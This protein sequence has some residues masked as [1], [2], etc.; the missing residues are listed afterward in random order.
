MKNIFNLRSYILFLSRNKLYTTIT[1][2]GFAVSL[3]FVILMAIYAKDEFTKDHFHENGDRIYHLTTG[4]GWDVVAAPI[5]EDLKGRYPEIES[6]T[7]LDSGDKLVETSN[8][9][10]YSVKSLSVDSSFFR[11]F[12]FPFLEGTASE[13][14]NSASG[15]VLS[16]EFAHKLFGSKSPLG[17]EIK[18]STF[19][20]TTSY[21][22]SGVIGKFENTMFKKCDI[23]LPII[24]SAYYSAC[25]N[26]LMVL[27]R[28]G[29]DLKAKEADMSEFLRGFFWIF[30]NDLNTKVEFI[31]LN[32][33]Y[34]NPARINGTEKGDERF[35]LILL[36]AAAMILIF[37]VIN[38]INLSVAQSGFRAREMA[39]RRL[40]GSPVAE[41]FGKFIFESFTMCFIAFVIGLFLA[42]VALPV[43]ND[44]VQASISFS[45]A[46][47]VSNI[48]IALGFVMLL[49]FIS[50]IIPAYVITKFKP[51][52]VVKGTFKY[53][54]KKVYSK[55]LIAFQYCI[56]IVLIGSA[57]T[58]VNQTSFMRDI[59]PGYEIENLFV[60]NHQVFTESQTALRGDL[61][62][63]P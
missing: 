48:L 43:F 38:Y 54:T 2:F 56:T 4:D 10:K 34:F 3:M 11:M 40:L 12:D 14:F 57:M 8:K 16:E 50:G 39:T 19:G 52:E 36:S 55:V 22:V 30:K 13:V 5:G 6:Y 59:E 35:I 45:T 61:M 51:I 26:S 24:N 32:D 18:I 41:L 15:V 42:V 7:R 37:A 1:I 31:P 63:I 21:I 23:I 47:T 58:I 20:E 9:T 60:V 53:R 17:E 28:Q 46:F 44:V 62:A 27:A 33:T 29:A 25:N 49:G